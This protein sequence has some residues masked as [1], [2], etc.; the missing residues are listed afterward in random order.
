MLLRLIDR[1]LKLYLRDPLSVFFSFLSVLMVIIMYAV[2]LGDN[3][4]ANVRAQ[5]GDVPY[6]DGLVYSWLMAGL[7][8]MSTVTVPINV[9]SQFNQDSKSGA[10]YDFYAAPLAREQL[11]LSYLI[12]SIVVTTLMSLVNLLAG[13]IFLFSQGIPLMPVDSWLRVVLL[14]VVSASV[15]SSLFFL[16][17]LIMGGSEAFGSLGGIVGTLIG[18]FA[19]IYV[20]IGVMGDSVRFGVNLLPFAHGVTLMRQA[21]MPLYL[22]RIFEGAPSAIRESFTRFYGINLAYATYE[23]TSLELVLMFIGFGALFFAISTLLIKRQKVA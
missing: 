7:V 5:V 3:T 22:D 17:A 15:F 21:Y 23:P 4:L 9:L 16:I 12:S 11:I 19:G 20:P 13:Q 1:N 14:V 6:L 8:F 10:I 18:F 2:F